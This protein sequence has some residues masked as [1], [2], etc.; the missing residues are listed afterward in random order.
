MNQKMR[1]SCSSSLD[2][3]LSPTVDIDVNLPPNSTQEMTSS[4]MI[5]LVGSLV[6]PKMSET[7]LPLSL[8]HKKALVFGTVLSDLQLANHQQDSHI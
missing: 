3:E 8:P 6:L 5:Y 4:N 2:V 7:H 1:V